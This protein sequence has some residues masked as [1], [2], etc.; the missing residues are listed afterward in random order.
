MNKR[1]R[2]LLA[3]DHSFI[4]A[5]IRSLLEPHYDLVG[6]VGDG[7]S[8]VEATGRLKPDL[9]ILD[10]TMP[11]LNGIDAARQIKKVWPQA[12]LL[13][14]SMHASPVYLREALDAGGSGYVL[15]SSAVEELRTAIQKVLKGQIYVA[16][17]L[18]RGI[19]DGV[20]IPGL[21]HG[22]ASVQL[23]ERQREVLQLIAEGRGNKEIATI[24]RVSVKTV[25]FHRGRIMNKLGVHTVAELIR[26]AIQ[27]GLVGE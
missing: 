4:L 16:P 23:T 5:G 10:V 21:G 8:L 18:E 24:L 25:E 6:Q 26:W 17:S 20:R 13:F 14:L 27:A 15:K 11:L 7:R 1:A 19:L 12:K 9:V 22:R 2:I 3:D